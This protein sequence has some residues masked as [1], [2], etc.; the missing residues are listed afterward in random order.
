MRPQCC[1]WPRRETREIGIV[2]DEG[3]EVADGAHDTCDDAP[4]ELGSLCGAALFDDGADA[5]GADN[6]PD[7][8]GDATDWGD[9]GLDGEEMADL[10]DREPDEGQG[11]EPED[12]KGDEVIDRGA[13]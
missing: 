7:E 9:D 1:R 6:A 8:E 10:V 12:E 13:E 3:C 2:D 11:A 4:C 5:A